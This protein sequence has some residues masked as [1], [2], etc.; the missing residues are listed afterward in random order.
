MAPGTC[1][2][3]DGLV[4]NGRRGPWSCEGSMPQCRGML[5]PGS[6]SEWVGEQGE[7]E[8]DGGFSEEELGKGIAFKV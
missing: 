3:E 2:A 1:V 8:G 6:W 7:R 4:I 5:G